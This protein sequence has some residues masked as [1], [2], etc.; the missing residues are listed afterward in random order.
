MDPIKV[1]VEEYLRDQ[2]IGSH[3]DQVVYENYQ[4]EKEVWEEFCD[5]QMAVIS[6]LSAQELYEISNKTSWHNLGFMIAN[7]KYEWTEPMKAGL[8]LYLVREDRMR[9][10]KKIGEYARKFF[11]FGGVL[12]VLGCIWDLRANRL[13]RDR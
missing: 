9:Q 12:F 8:D 3:P 2:I 13:A 11:I 1:H 7:S 6:K 5:D 4:D 10:A